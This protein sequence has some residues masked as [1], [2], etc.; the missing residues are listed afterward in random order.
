MG[1]PAR[2][3][4]GYIETYPLPGKPKLRG[5]DASHAWISVYAG[6]GCWYDYDPTNNSGAIFAFAW[7]RLGLVHSRKEST[8]LME[9]YRTVKAFDEMVTQDGWGCAA[10]NTSFHKKQLFCFRRWPV[11]LRRRKIATNSRPKGASWSKFPEF[12]EEFVAIRLSAG[13]E[14]L[15]Q[16]PAA[17]PRCLRPQYE[18]LGNRLEHMGLGEL[19]RRNGL[20]EG[21]QGQGI[22]YFCQLFLVCRR[23]D[24][25]AH[26]SWGKMSG[27]VVYTDSTVLSF[28]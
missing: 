1:I 27:F 11:S 8:M 7:V 24:Q 21:K 23:S 13:A 5:S 18:T 19:V 10:G 17:Q 2:Y 25:A 15:P 4:S 26:L 12:A 28:L 20:Q 6:N 14:K 9:K 3:V 16:R 22:M